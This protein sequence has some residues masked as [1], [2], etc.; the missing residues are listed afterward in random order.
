MRFY[1]NGNA[2]FCN[3]VLI[4]VRRSIPQ[5]SHPIFSDNLVKYDNFV[6]R[7][8]GH[9]TRNVMAWESLFFSTCAHTLMR[10]NAIHYFVLAPKIFECL[11][12]DARLN[13]L[14]YQIRSTICHAS[15]VVARVLHKQTVFR[16]HQ[17]YISLIWIRNTV[18]FAAAFYWR[19]LVVGWVN[20]ECHLHRWWDEF[21]PH[22]HTK[23]RK[24]ME[25]EKKR[26][27]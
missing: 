20:K 19:T 25:Q 7:T 23:T 10:N 11:Y 14:D 21:F 12:C 17:K 5:E 27:A 1:K 3:V 6:S 2:P 18:C 13:S 22:Q 9:Q 26:L 4:K 24:L 16:F 15:F 8:S